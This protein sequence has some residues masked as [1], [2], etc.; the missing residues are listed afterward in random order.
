LFLFNVQNHEARLWL[1][2]LAGI[3]SVIFVLSSLL[4]QKNDSLFARMFYR[5]SA[6]WM[7]FFYFVLIAATLSIV[8]YAVLPIDRYAGAVVA[9]VLFSLAG[10]LGLYSVINAEVIR[11]THR[12]I[13]LPHVPEFWKSRSLVFVSDIHLGHIHGAGY[14]ERITRR[15]NEL[16]PEVLLI[17]GDIFDGPKID[18]IHAVQPF[19]KITAPL[20]AYFISGNH[21]E[22][23][24]THE[25]FQAIRQSGMHIL[26]AETVNLNGINFTGVD[27]LKTNSREKFN[28]VVQG[29]VLP[30]GPNILLKHVPSDLDLAEAKGFNASFSGHT[31]NGQLFPFGYLA[32]RSY[33]FNYG[34]EMLKSMSVMVSSGV[35]TWGPPGRFGTRSE[36]VVV[37]FRQ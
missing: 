8:L 37:N 19:D 23:R 29:L 35:G 15:V 20:G 11:V 31:H 6:I 17:G 14:A 3:L 10:L 26:D 21:D 25:F 1:G 30:E 32:R 13:S 33:G 9:T 5:I 12:T 2:V 36:I 16:K 27:Y 34:L 7:V 22:F 4:A 18:A 24:D 28:A